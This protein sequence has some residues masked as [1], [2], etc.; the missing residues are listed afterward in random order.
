MS[1]MVTWRR[2]REEAMWKAKTAGYSIKFDLKLELSAG[3]Q[4]ALINKN[5]V[6]KVMRPIPGTNKKELLFSK[7]FSSSWIAKDTIDSLLFLCYSLF[8]VLGENEQAEQWFIDTLSNFKGVD[9]PEQPDPSDHT[10]IYKY[11]K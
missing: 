6:L 11:Y 5:A 4:S 3:I 8:I 9:Y 2:D 1:R 10:K 7:E